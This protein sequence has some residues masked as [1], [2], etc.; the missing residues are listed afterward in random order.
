VDCRSIERPC[1]RSAWKALHKTRS[2]FCKVIFEISW[3]TISRLKDIFVVRLAEI[4]RST[5]KQPI[6]WV[7]WLITF[8]GNEK[9]SPIAWP[10]R[11]TKCV[12]IGEH[13]SLFVISCQKQYYSCGVEFSKKWTEYTVYFELFWLCFAM[14][15]ILKMFYFRVTGRVKFFFFITRPQNF[16]CIPIFSNFRFPGGALSFINQN[17]HTW[18]GISHAKETSDLEM[19]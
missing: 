12:P 17:N 15:P 8:V 14:R 13:V 3:S 9:H 6:D 11:V 5:C 7:S 18:S 4:S 2:P 10:G 1:V 16:F 19:R